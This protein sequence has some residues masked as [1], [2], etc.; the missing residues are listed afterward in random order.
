MYYRQSGTW[1]LEHVHKLTMA[2]IS[3]T[4]VHHDAA[5]IPFA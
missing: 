2:S 5:D 3:E 4:G 1:D